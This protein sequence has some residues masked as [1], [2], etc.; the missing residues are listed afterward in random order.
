M[1]SLDSSCVC[2][3][4]HA[5]RLVHLCPQISVGLCRGDVRFQLCVGES[6][7]SVAPNRARAHTHTHTKLPNNKAVFLP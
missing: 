3:H 7:P 4:A 2:V 1:S 5:P 6:F